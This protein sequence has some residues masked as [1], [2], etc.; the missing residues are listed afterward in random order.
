ML[1]RRSNASWKGQGLVEFALLLALVAL[2]AFLALQ[3]M[4]IS[5]REAYCRVAS[6]F[7]ENACTDA[8]VYCSTSFDGKTGH[9]HEE[10]EDNEDRGIDGWEARRGHWKVEDGQMCTSKHARIFNTCSTELPQGDYEIR[11][12]GATLMQGN[13]YGVF[14]RVSNV[15]SHFNGYTFQYDPGYGGGAFIY[16]K[17]VNGREL[18]PPFA[19]AWA[20]NYDWYG[21]PHDIRIVVKGNTFTTYIDGQEVLTA[22]DDTYTEGAVGLRSWDHTQACFDGFTIAPA[23]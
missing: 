16:R 11:L 18:W 14:F 8:G 5:V 23:P 17:W 21:E 22:T 4:G 9:E 1:T 10:E 6:A 15:G 2:V 7:S 3:A 19:I 13:G 12:D 20:P